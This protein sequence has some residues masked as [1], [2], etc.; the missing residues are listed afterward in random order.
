MSFLDIQMG[1]SEPAPI[2]PIEL[3]KCLA[4]GMLFSAAF[5]IIFSTI[6]LLG[7]AFGA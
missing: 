4:Q 5:I 2:G 6:V 1:G 7:V 3:L